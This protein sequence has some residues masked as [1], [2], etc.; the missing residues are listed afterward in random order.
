MSCNISIPL[1]RIIDDVAEVLAGNYIS[2]DNPFLN[3]SVLTD[4]TFRGDITMDTE[5]RN[6]LC[7]ILKTCGITAIELEWLDRPTVVGQVAISSTSLGEVVT[8]WEN[9]KALVQ[10]YGFSEKYNTKNFYT[11]YAAM[12]ADK[13]ELSAGATID[14]DGDTTEALNGTYVYNGVSFTKAPYDPLALSRAYTDTAI[15]GIPESPLRFVEDFGA[16]P[17]PADST[18]AFQA[19]MALGG[20]VHTKSNTIYVVSD[21]VD[22]KANSTLYLGAGSKINSPLTDKTLFNLSG[23]GARIVGNGALIES[24]E[25]FVG[26]QGAP[27][28]A[29]IMLN[30]NNC[31]VEGVKLK[32]YH[33]FGILIKDTTGHTIQNNSIDGGV[34]FSFYDEGDSNKLSRGAIIYD[35]VGIDTLDAALNITGNKI[36]NDVQGITAGNFGNTANPRG[37]KIQGNHLYNIYDHAM[38]LDAVS[39]SGCIISGNTLVDCRRPIVAGGVGTII[40]GNTFIGVTN[41][42]WFEQYISLRDPINCIVSDNTFYGF[43]SGIALQGIVDNEVSGNI[44]ANNTFVQTAVGSIQS[45]IRLYDTQVVNNNTISGNKITAFTGG[46]YGAIDVDCS[47]IG[48]GNVVADNQVTILSSGGYGMRIA[49]QS[50]CAITK[51]TIT[52]AFDST[53]ATTI[54]SIGIAE[55]LDGDISSNKMS[56]MTKGANV[57]ARG[58]VGDATCVGNII[59]DNIFRLDS[60]GLTDKLA[61]ANLSH[62]TNTLRDNV[63]DTRSAMSGN[64]VIAVGSNVGTITNQNIKAGNMVIVQPQDTASAQELA[65]RAYSVEQADGVATITVTG[66]VTVAAI[67]MKYYIS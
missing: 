32:N 15:A 57:T 2:V 22:V 63:Y 38:Y 13:S 24:P 10:G 48:V 8:T 45:C 3:E 43:G 46:F 64:V 17:S 53:V 25:N 62:T 34:P 59:K 1:Q 58:I 11:S 65:G 51:N 21:T 18:A 20:A 66:A 23:D 35:N 49:K 28:F 12:L 7:A 56:F 33:R 36:K 31:L 37:I 29:I 55:F 41:T 27:T 52:A 14:V 47:T 4:T 6:A 67:N 40:N 50:E 19:A 30:A 5:A 54:P 16:E 44:I 60:V 61:V 42:T 26:P 9:L 39:A